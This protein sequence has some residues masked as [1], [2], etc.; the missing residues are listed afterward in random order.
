MDNL[1]D[2]KP[3]EIFETLNNSLTIEEIKR[4][5]DILKA[6]EAYK[7]AKNQ[8]DNSFAESLKNMVYSMK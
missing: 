2:L 4:F 7:D 6:V 1:K 3:S 8:G 5:V